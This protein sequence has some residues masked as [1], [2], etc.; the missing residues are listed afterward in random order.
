MVLLF[1]FEHISPSVFVGL[2]VRN[3]PSH[4]PISGKRSHTGCKT[5]NSTSCHIWHERKVAP[6]KLPNNSAKRSHCCPCCLADDLLLCM[7][8]KELSD[9]TSSPTSVIFKAASASSMF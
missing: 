8:S 4:A 5:E 1:F 2:I 7:L 9:S 3:V 6:S